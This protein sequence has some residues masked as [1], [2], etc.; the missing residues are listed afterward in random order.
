MAKHMV[1]IGQSRNKHNILME[2]LEITYHSAGFSIDMIILK[3]NI[4]ED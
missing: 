4:E 2:N 3:W 1:Y